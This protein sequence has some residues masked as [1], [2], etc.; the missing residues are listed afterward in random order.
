MAPQQ[1]SG[2]EVAV[3]ETSSLGDHWVQGRKFIIPSAV[4]EGAGLGTIRRS[5]VR[6][7]EGTGARHRPAVTVGCELRA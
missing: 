6:K 7:T 5:T 1:C 3:S 4:L 2:L